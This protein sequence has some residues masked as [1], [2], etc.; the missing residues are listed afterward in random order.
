MVADDLDRLLD[1]F[2]IF[3]EFTRS[4]RHTAIEIATVSLDDRGIVDILEH[5]RIDGAFDVIDDRLDLFGADIDSLDTLGSRRS[6]WCIE[7]V[8]VSE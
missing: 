4:V 1:H 2:R 6:D 7:E 5:R 3:V 8:S